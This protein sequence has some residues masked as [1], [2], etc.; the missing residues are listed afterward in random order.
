[1]AI[2]KIINNPA[3]THGA[4]RALIRYVLQDKKVKE[5]YVD[6]QGPFNYDEINV[7]NVYQAFLEEKK[8]W[9]KDSG[10]MCM[11]SV[12]SFHEKDFVTPREC[13]EIG[14]IF[15]QEFFPD[16]QNLIA[17]HQDKKHLHIHIVTNTVSFA[18][19]HKLH[20]KKNDL[21]VQKDFTNKLCASRG[22][23]VAE[24]GKHFDGSEIEPG[25]IRAWNEKKYQALI[26][27]E[28]ESYM[29]DCAEAIVE[30]VP[31]CSDSHE[32]V[33]KMELRGWIVSW[34]EKRG[35]VV[36]R[37]N[38]GRS[39]RDTNLTRT[40]TFNIGLEEIIDEFTDTLTELYNTS[41]SA[42]EL[43]ARKI[44][45]LILFVADLLFNELKKALTPD[46]AAGKG[47]GNQKTPG[48]TARDE[49]AK[50]DAFLGKISARTRD[51]RENA[52]LLIRNA[53][54]AI[55]GSRANRRVS[56]AETA[57]IGDSEA[58]SKF[59]EGERRS[60]EQQRAAH[61]RTRGI[62]LG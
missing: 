48:G 58:L 18:D 42:E 61:K 51:Y 4:M 20:M 23:H 47:R 2:N 46:N 14:Q 53:D 39:V 29:I 31:E 37:N 49:R 5:G 16:F 36:F 34:N 52:D 22:L 54:D 60:A 8:L 59:V 62:E 41:G 27:E 30:T 7:N 25:E 55:E 44:G 9:D 33:A 28:R 57:E 24:K 15:C 19:G 35:H 43:Y 11:H 56:D 50:F 13:L 26:N 21:Q 45:E 3:K 40:F 38:S 32:F 12:I 17:I 10:R 1:M 6:F